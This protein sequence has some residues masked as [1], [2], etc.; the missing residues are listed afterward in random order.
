MPPH[1]ERLVLQTLAHRAQS[2]P[3]LAYE[4]GVDDALLLQ[5]LHRLDANGEVHL[6]GGRWVVGLGREG[7]ATGSE[8]GATPRSSGLRAGR[9]LA[10]SAVVEIDDGPTLDLVAPRAPEAR[11]FDVRRVAGPLAALAVGSLLMLG[12]ASC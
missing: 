6:R 8:P 4:L 5:V 3:S 7:M 2:A 9:R 12:L 1:I 10:Y 11:G